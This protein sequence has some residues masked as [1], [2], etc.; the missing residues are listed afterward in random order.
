[1]TSDVKLSHYFLLIKVINRDMFLHSN[2]SENN[3]KHHPLCECRETSTVEYISLHTVF[4]LNVLKFELQYE[5]TPLQICFCGYR[6]IQLFCDNVEGAHDIR[7][8]Q[9]A[10]NEILLIS[11]NW[12]KF[13]QRQP[14]EVFYKKVVLKDFALFTGEHL[15]QSLFLSC[16]F[17]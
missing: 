14:P 4:I 7:Y 1:M 15:Y 8:S 17:I 5:W 9:K 2:H 12:F 11:E 16:N 13:Y 3:L 10:G 6:V